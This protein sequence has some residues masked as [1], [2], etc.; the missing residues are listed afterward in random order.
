MKRFVTAV[1]AL[2]AVFIFANASV[3]RAAEVAYWKEWPV[4]AKGMIPAC[5]TDIA[6]LGG[7][8][9]LK[10]LSDTYC[11]LNLGNYVTH[12]NPTGNAAYKARSTKYPDGRTAVMAFEKAGIGFTVDHKGGRIEFGVIDLKDGASKASKDQGHPM[13]PTTC[14]MCHVSFND[15]CVSGM[16]GNRLKSSAK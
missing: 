14:A 10:S 5:G 15:A 7:D 3:S 9:I 11:K 6:G 4:V 1:V 2:S 16:C 8:D 12:L 13:N